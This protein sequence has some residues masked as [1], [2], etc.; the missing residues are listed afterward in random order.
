[1]ESLS[2]DADQ[3]R[4]MSFHPSGDY[5]VVGTNQPVIRLYDINTAQCYVCSFPSHYHMGGITSIKYSFDGKIYCSGSRD[6]S[7]KLWDG[8]SSKCVGTI[9]QAHEG[10]QISS[11]TF[12][13]SGKV[14]LLY[15]SCFIVRQ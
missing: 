13:R 3:V 11:V 5:L 4:C 7:I 9:S 12:S 15:H 6:G 10:A 14:S 2:Q 1:M 8:V